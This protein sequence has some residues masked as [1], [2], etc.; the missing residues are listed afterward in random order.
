M[1][2]LNKNDELPPSGIMVFAKKAEYSETVTIPSDWV[3]HPLAQYNYWQ[4]PIAN[5]DIAA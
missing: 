2:W 5:Y 4:Y 3:R 1:P